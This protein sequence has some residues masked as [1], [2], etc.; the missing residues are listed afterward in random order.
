MRLKILTT[1]RETTE[2]LVVKGEGERAG[3]GKVD[4]EG[5]IWEETN[6]IKIRKQ[7]YSR[8]ERRLD[9]NKEKENNVKTNLRNK[10]EIQKR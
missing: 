1:R 5:K 10:R 8:N 6:G 9:T 7:R 3:R 4:K 2:R